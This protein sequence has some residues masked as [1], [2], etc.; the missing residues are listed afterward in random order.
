MLRT[1]AQHLES[2]RDGRVVYIGS[3]RVKDVTTHP[4]FSGAAQTVADLFDLKADPSR[5][6][7]WFEEGGERYSMYYLRP[8]TRDDLRKRTECHRAIAELTLGMFGRSPDHVP[9]YVTGMTAHPEVFDENRKGFGQN[10]LNYYDYLRKN[11][12]YATYA[13]LPPQAMRNPELFQRENR[14]VPSLR[15]VREDDDGVVISG[16]K[17]LA[18]GA[19]LANEIWIGNIL[20]LAKEQV[21]E[22]ITCSIPVNVP[23]LSLW[24]RRP[25][26]TAVSDPR[27]AP[28]SWRYDE[29]DSMVLCEEVKVPWE[30]VFIHRDAQ[31]ARD[32]YVR[33][34]GH[35]FSNHQAG[36]R[37][38]SK[39]TFLT[40][41]ASRITQA[42]GADKIPAVMDTLGRFAA[43]E[44]IVGSMV[45]GQIENFE[46][47]A[48]GEFKGY[49]RRG[50]YGTANWCYENYPVMIDAVRELCGGGVYQMPADVSVL[51]DPALKETFE[52]YWYT[53]QMSAADRM[54]L[55]R[56][57]WDMTGSEFA[58]RHLTYEKCYL[59]AHFLV[60]NLSYRE[61]PWDMFHKLVDGVLAKDQ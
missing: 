16:M 23:G 26:A 33:T 37:F 4:A 27:E 5:S 60:R 7:L 46:D 19:V 18:T 25:I 42:T 38:W 31:L 9:S 41:L 21:A 14:T 13:V 29:T 1:G 40:G 32:I 17:M 57:A 10:L 2:L 8:K 56:L 30:R 20:P 43:M 51:T 52:T 55:F 36:V 49:N 24:S 11:D 6:D 34:P 48:G 53:P 3:E 12:L 39:V 28:L 22:S 58:S 45:L 44:A 54:K 50:V 59:G 61:A 47:W 15:V 35:S